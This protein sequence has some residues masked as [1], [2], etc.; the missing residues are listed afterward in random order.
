[1]IQGLSPLGK[2]Q[3]P[4]CSSK[5]T[6]PGA[7]FSITTT[8]SN[9]NLGFHMFSAYYVPDTVLRGYQY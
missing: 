7:W 1:M 9:N 5:S 2:A 6:G 4:T 8:N 3:L